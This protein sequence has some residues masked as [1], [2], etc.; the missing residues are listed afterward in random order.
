MDQQLKMVLGLI[1]AELYDIKNNLPSTNQQQRIPESMIFALKHG[2][3]EVIDQ[4]INL[5]LLANNQH[6]R[7][8]EILEEFNNRVPNNPTFDFASIYFRISGDL[9]I[10]NSSAKSFLYDVMT[11]ELLT[12][13][14]RFDKLFQYLFQQDPQLEKVLLSGFKK[15]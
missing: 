3:E 14:S 11:Y 10:S 15:N 6:V 2:F 5:D 7:I 12:N 1:F 8:L 13:N 4:V 9:Q